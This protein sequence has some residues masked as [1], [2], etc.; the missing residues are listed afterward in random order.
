VYVDGKSVKQQ[1]L[2]N[3]PISKSIQTQK[4]IDT[5]KRHEVIPHTLARVNFL[6]V[7]FI[8]AYGQKV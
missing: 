5:N 4:A 8:G 1:Q 3:N 6:L 7:P 2:S